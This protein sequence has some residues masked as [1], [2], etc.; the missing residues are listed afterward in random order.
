MQRGFKY[1]SVWISAGNLNDVQKHIYGIYVRTFSKKSENNNKSRLICKKRLHI[2]SMDTWL[3]I[4]QMK[5][6]KN[7][8][9]NVDVMF[10]FILLGISPQ[11]ICSPYACCV[12]E[13][14]VWP[15]Y[16]NWVKDL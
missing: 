1:E 5:L 16:L 13:E 14:M 10:I 7:L 2:W 11:M 12:S 9:T 6:F 3:L 4:S 8:S 15:R